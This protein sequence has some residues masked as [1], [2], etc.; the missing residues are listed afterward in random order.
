MLHAIIKYRFVNS[1]IRLQ[2][3]KDRDAALAGNKV[4]EPY[5]LYQTLFA[6]KSTDEG[7]L[8]FEGGEIIR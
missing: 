6:Y 4:D 7:D 2:A 1:K 8:N 5:S 3:Q